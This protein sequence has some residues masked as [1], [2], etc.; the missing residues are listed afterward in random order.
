MSSIVL[1]VLSLVFA[2]LALLAHGWTATGVGP[3]VLA[4]AGGLW[5]WGMEQLRDRSARQHRDSGFLPGTQ[6]LAL[7][8]A[9][10]WFVTGVVAAAWA[11]AALRDKWPVRP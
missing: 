11:L 2:V 6:H 1:L 4:V 10:G 3:A 5:Q 8:G 7:A 9:V